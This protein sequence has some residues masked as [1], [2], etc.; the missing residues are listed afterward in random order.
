MTNSYIKTE[1]FSK[2]LYV[3]V[4]SKF[5]PIYQYLYKSLE[6]I[7]NQ[8]TCSDTSNN[9]NLTMHRFAILMSYFPVHPQLTAVLKKIY[10]LL[11]ITIGQEI[12]L[13]N[14]QQQN[15]NHH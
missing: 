1:N 14:K 7:Y 6:N 8:Q 9:Q 3:K 11:R 15:S 2:L 10:R 12:N 5:L 4:T 13:K